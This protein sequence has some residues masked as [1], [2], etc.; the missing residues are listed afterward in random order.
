MAYFQWGLTTAYGNSTTAQS[1]SGSTSATL[2]GLSASATYHYRV[3]A[4]NSAGTTY[5]GDMTFTSSAGGGATPGSTVW[6]K[7]F[8]GGPGVGCSVTRDASN[9]VFVA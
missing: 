5:G 6:A 3:V 8:T 9:Y 2:S 4:Y 7:E 1:A